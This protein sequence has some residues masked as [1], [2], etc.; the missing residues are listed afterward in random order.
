M[1]HKKH[2]TRTAVEMK[3]KTDDEIA[4]E[5]GRRREGETPPAMCLC[6]MLI[7]TITLPAADAA[8]RPTAPRAVCNGCCRDVPSIFLIGAP[9]MTVCMYAL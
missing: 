3:Q 9:R 5:A 8:S 1:M 7:L 6:L 2:D 4:S